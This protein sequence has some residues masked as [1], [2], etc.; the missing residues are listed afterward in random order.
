[1]G[2]GVVFA[3]T[4]GRHRLIGDNYPDSYERPEGV[5]N[6]ASREPALLWIG[7]LAPVVAAV[8]AF[9]FAASPT[10]QSCVNAVAAALAGAIVAFIVKSD[11]LL[12]VVTGLIQAVIALIVGLGAHWE[13]TQQALL[14]TALGVVAAVIVRDRVTAPAPA[15]TVT[16]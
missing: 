6:P 8:A 7:T 4:T 13:S 11:N 16:T 15:A 2:C 5:M 14:A 12:P 3:V 1:V 10:V 9:V